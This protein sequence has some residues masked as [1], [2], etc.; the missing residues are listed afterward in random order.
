MK[1]A[2][3][4]DFLL[5]LGGAERVLKVFSEMF[6]DAPIFTLLYDENNVGK[7]FPKEKIICSNLQNYP[8]FLRKRHRLFTS[9]M[10]NEI[11]NFD[12]SGFDLVLS[13]SS[14]FAHGI[15]VPTG[16]KHVCYC[17]SPMRYAWDHSSEYIEENNISGLKKIAYSLLIKRLREWDF[18]AAKRP[19]LYI[20]NSK[21][22]S[23]RIKK[24]YKL[25]SKVVYPPVDVQ[26]FKQTSEHKDY[27]L[28]VS[29]LTPYKKI[30]LAVS[31]FNKIGK[32]LL[33]IGDG[34]HKKYLESVSADNIEFLGFCSDSD[35]SSYMEG[36]RALIFPGEE[37]FGIVPLEAMACGK[38][39]L[40]YGK[41]GALE[42]IIPGETGE[43]FYESNIQSM[44]G[45]LAKLLN[46]EKKYKSSFLRKHAESF[47][48]DAF[49]KNI[50]KEIAF[51]NQ[52]IC[53]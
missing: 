43:L 38:P 49:E 4:H 20:A 19:D 30:D 24:Y 51:V 18:L 28:I 5:K 35:V 15:V 36:C 27:F 53:C 10:P 46:N 39:V 44:E 32:K 1:V 6:P 2:L 52:H 47:G 16:I 8:S 7:V 14:A 33:I 17:H 40:A 41:G 34:P 25:D 26:K 23:S 31:L 11:E 37:D 45:A 42:T 3:V 13:S 12:F 9:R 29:T 21:N 22:V 48:R 50:K